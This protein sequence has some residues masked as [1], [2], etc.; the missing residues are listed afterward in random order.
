MEIFFV[1]IFE[2]KRRVI[3]QVKQQ[4]D[5]FDQHKLRGAKLSFSAT[6][7]LCVQVPFLFAGNEG[8]KTLIASAQVHRLACEYT[9]FVLA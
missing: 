7:Q 8:T 6:V 1:Q 4:V 2:R 9:L 5:L 3:E